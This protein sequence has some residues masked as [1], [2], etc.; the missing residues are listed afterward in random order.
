[1]PSW[2]TRAEDGSPIL[3]EE[4]PARLSAWALRPSSTYSLTWEPAPILGVTNHRSPRFPVSGPTL[5][6]IAAREAEHKRR[7]LAQARA[8][9]RATVV[10]MS[11][12]TPAQ[13]ASYERDKSFRVVGSAGGVYRIRYGSAGNVDWFAPGAVDRPTGILCAHP[14]LWDGGDYLPTPASM[15]AQALALITDEPGFVRDANIHWGERP[16]HIPA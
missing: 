5:E 14:D 10:L 15:L 7:Q 6:E 12:L 2:W 3:I 4:P 13:Q 8:T 1:M 9:E 11:F 16:A